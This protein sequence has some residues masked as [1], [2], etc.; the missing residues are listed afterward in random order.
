DTIK[1][2]I[3]FMENN[4][5]AVIAGCKVM[6]PDGKIDGSC[7]RGFPTPFGSFSHLFGLS[8]IFPNS[9][10]FGTYKLSYLD[11]EDESV[12]DSVSGCFVFCKGDVLKKLGGFDEDFFMYGEDLD[13]CF[14]AQ[15]YGKVYYTPSTSIIHIK[16]E[17]TKRSS[18]DKL[19]VF[20]NAMEIFTRKHYGKNKLLLQLLKFGIRF[21]RTFA[22]LNEKFPFWRFAILDLIFTLLGFSI[23]TY[24]KFGKLFYYPDYAVPWVYV[25]PPIVFVFSLAISGAYRKD[26]SIVQRSLLGFMFGFF[27]LSTLPYFFKSFAF[28]RGVILLTTAISVSAGVFGRFILLLYS[29]TFGIEAIKRIALLSSSKVKPEIKNSIRRL[30]LGRPVKILG[31]IYADQSEFNQNKLEDGLGTIENIFQ[32]IK[33]NS[34]TDIFIVDDKL[35]YSLVVAAMKRTSLLSA[36]FHVYNQG[37]QITNLNILTNYKFGISKII[38]DKIL[39]ILFLFSYP[40]LYIFS[41]ELRINNYLSK[42]IKALFSMRPF[43]GSVPKLGSNKNSSAVFVAS[44]ITKEKVIEQNELKQIEEYYTANSSLLLDCEIILSILFEKTVIKESIKC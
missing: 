19:F 34:I 38:R 18:L 29:R 12:V 13:L 2:M 36:Q 42:T 26:E 30:F 27:F 10:I 3:G 25:A 37:N 33:L 15:K 40:L 4:S 6:M 28:S 43:V 5:N 44:L 39:E 24:Q 7:K 8:K 20:Y 31:T 23:S 32:V 11:F 9:K 22:Q 35:N 21:R 41:K 1:T 14:R 17:S 16:G